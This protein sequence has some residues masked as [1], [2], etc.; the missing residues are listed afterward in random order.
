MLRSR[1][2]VHS[3]LGALDQQEQ[4]PRVCRLELLREPTTRLVRDHDAPGHHSPRTQYSRLVRLS[5]LL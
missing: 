2:P 4:Q 1:R 3:R 5:R